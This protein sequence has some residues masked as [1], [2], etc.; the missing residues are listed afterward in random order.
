M[1][2]QYDEFKK[3]L[4]QLDKQ[5]AKKMKDVLQLKNVDST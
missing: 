3:Y 4:A 1:K 2:K 5:K